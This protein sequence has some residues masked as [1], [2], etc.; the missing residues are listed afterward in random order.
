MPQGAVENA[1]IRDGFHPKSLYDNPLNDPGVG[2]VRK[3]EKKNSTDFMMEY[4]QKTQPHQNRQLQNQLF[5]RLLH[6]LLPLATVVVEVQ[7][8]QAE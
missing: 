5:K 1:M 4:S 6:R 2:K 7:Q 3:K 8:N